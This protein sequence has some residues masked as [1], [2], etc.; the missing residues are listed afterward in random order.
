MNNLSIALYYL[1]FVVLASVF[2]KKEPYNQRVGSPLE[3]SIII[4]PFD[5]HLSAL[6]VPDEASDKYNQ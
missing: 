1:A 3:E 6:D 4:N 5:I 2:S